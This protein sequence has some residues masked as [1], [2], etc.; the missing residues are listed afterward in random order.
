MKHGYIIQRGTRPDGKQLW[1]SMN[2][3]CNDWRSST[4]V[5]RAFIFPSFELALL[6]CEP[7]YGDRMIPFE[8]E[9]VNFYDADDKQ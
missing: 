3:N 9:E 8:F 5:R 7:E 2:G 1:F 4:D 6:F